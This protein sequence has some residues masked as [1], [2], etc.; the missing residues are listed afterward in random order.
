[1]SWP[2]QIYLAHAQ[3]ELEVNQEPAVA[4]RVIDLARSV[5]PLVVFEVPYVQ[6]AAKIL[7]Q[8]GDLENLRVA[9]QT[10]LADPPAQSLAS[11]AVLPAPPA[12]ALTPRQVFLLWD[13]FYR[14]ELQLGLSGVSR[15]DELRECRGRAKAALEK[16]GYDDR[17]TASTFPGMFEISV[18]LVERHG[19]S[20]PYLRRGDG[21]LKGRTFTLHGGVD[22][23][24]GGWRAGDDEVERVGAQEGVSRKRPRKDAGA[25]A[26]T[27]MDALGMPLPPFLRDLLAHLPPHTG[28]PVDVDA[29]L[30]ALRKAVLPPRP[31]AP[32]DVL[33]GAALR[34]AEHGAPR[35]NGRDAFHHSS[36]RL[37]DEPGRGREE[38]MGVKRGSDSVGGNWK[39]MDDDEGEGEIR[40][41]PGED[42]AGA[43]A[44][45]F[46]QRQL[47]RRLGT[48]PQGYP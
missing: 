47:H 8:L 7:L 26:V 22:D 32:D 39:D 17:G 20:V 43:R 18:D 34:P 27:Y 46:R 28:V 24:H 2:C 11:A 13:M 29:A 14:Y 19:H 37:S 30:E 35:S 6:L 33:G 3:L 5:F 1:M 44:D 16:P 21:L 4:L 42:L 40:G 38:G 36:L 10:I 12:P 41:Y 9:F 23:H 45:I 25:E 48:A 31:E 15:L